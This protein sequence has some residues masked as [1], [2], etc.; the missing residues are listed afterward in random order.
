MKNFSSS[1]I[2]IALALLLGAYAFFFQR[3]PVKTDAKK[4]HLF[5][6][7]VSDDV[8]EVK[9]LNPSAQEGERSI[10]VK[11]DARDQWHIISPRALKADEEVMRGILTN[12]GGATPDTVI[13]HPDALT[14]YGFNDHS[15]VADFMF[16]GGKSR[17]LT[18]G[19]KNISGASIYV[20]ASGQTV[21][22]LVP[23]Y[24]AESLTKKLNYY[25][26]HTV[27]QTDLVQ[28]SRVAI[29]E[30]GKKMVLEKG[31]D[32]NWTL[33]QPVSEKADPMK[34]RDVL[35][36]TNDLKI[37]EF[38]TDHPSSLKI[39]GL[40]PPQ[41]VL[42]V[43]SSQAGVK[44]QVLDIGRQKLKTSEF[45]A[46]LKGQDTVFLISQRFVQSLDLKPSDFRD[47]TI[48]QFDASQAT[49]L[50]VTHGKKTILYVKDAKGQWNS[51]G[52]D[53][54]ND[55]G[56]G[57]LSQLALLT[58]SNFPGKGVKSGLDHPVYSV[59]VTL[60]DNKSRQYRFGD[61]TMGEIYLSMGQGSD[62][63]QVLS[64]VVAPLE[65]IF[66]PPKVGLTPTR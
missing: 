23:S 63:Y 27:I 22:D 55:E 6:D 5:S 35:T 33:T 50:S 61:E 65:G 53:K 17:A 37:D 19:D 47:K 3:G 2:L 1:L 28:A 20:K 15:A 13:D 29:T 49:R 10:D 36:A 31:K 18:I 9:L 7:F 46:R 45:F 30:H 48:L 24:V 39:Y 26:D 59:V 11:R 62:I 40:A 44:D 12:V 32:E 64:S 14:D 43:G 58:I 21:V 57:I 4:S 25:R 38:E 56:S 66:A 60:A 52:R 41:A 34:V 51:L 54:A 16:K 8:N 42:E